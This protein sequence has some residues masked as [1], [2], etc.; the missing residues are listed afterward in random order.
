MWGVQKEEYNLRFKK[1]LNY[2]EI[3]E[4]SLETNKKT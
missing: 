4:N 3:G 1:I 2:W